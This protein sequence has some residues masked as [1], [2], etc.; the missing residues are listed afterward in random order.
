MIKALRFLWMILGIVMFL[1]AISI[2]LP[3]LSIKAANTKI[4]D[5]I[6]LK[7]FWG[8][9]VNILVALFYTLFSLVGI[10]NYFEKNKVNYKALHPFLKIILWTIG[11]IICLICVFSIIH[12]L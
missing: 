12:D 4:M 1:Y 7:G 2:M 5:I 9:V 8:A 6:G 11:I 3:E 10:G